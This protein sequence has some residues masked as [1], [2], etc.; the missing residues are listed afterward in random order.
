MT[1]QFAVQKIERNGRAI[2]LYE[3]VRSAHWRCELECR[4][5]F[6]VAMIGSTGLKPDCGERYG[7]D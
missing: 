1:E 6:S 3:G 5:Q 2:Q 4:L 7:Q